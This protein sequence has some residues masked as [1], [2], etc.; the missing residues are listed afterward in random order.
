[1]DVMSCLDL[2]TG[3]RVRRSQ[4]LQ[5]TN[6]LPLPG[7]SGEP[8]QGGSGYSSYIL[9]VQI[10][11]ICSLAPCHYSPL[12]LSDPCHLKI[13]HAKETYT[14]L[15]AIPSCDITMRITILIIIIA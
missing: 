8:R 6:T 3:L 5:K 13:K 11:L 7:N 1:M 15:T 4:W 9:P 2:G 14:P 12:P 10:P